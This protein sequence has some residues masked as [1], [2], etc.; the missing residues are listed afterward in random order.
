MRVLVGCEFSGVV[1]DAFRRRGHDAWSCDILPTEVPGPHLHGD[2]LDALDLGWDLLI[3]HPPC[4]YL[5]ASGARWFKLRHPDL[6]R[7]AIAFARRLL[8]CP[9]P[10]ICIENPVGVLSSTLRKPDQVIQPYHFGH[11]ASKRTCLWLTGLPLLHAPMRGL[12]PVAIWTRDG[13]AASRWSNQTPCGADRTSQ[14]PRR[15]RERSRT[16]PGVAEAMANQWG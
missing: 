3:A 14:G 15:G 13:S 10:K 1:R 2:L 11:H 9:I 4:T 6:Q 7:S 12:P 5:A 16:F 8:E